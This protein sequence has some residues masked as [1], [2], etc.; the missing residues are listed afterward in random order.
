[1]PLLHSLVSKV[2]L[3]QVTRMA[4]KYAN[5]NFL[6]W[7]WSIFLHTSLGVEGWLGIG[8]V[9]GF[10]GFQCFFLFVII[11]ARNK[12]GSTIFTFILISLKTNTQIIFGFWLQSPQLDSSHLQSFSHSQWF[13]QDV[14]TNKQLLVLARSSL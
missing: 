6:T 12:L 5:V 13:S 8:L 14:K 9:V 10:N 4:T 1:M 11:D 3:I 7:I 2:K